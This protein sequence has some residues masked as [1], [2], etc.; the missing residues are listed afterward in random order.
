LIH[1]LDNRLQPLTLG[2]L[3]P[4]NK[5]QWNSCDKY[6]LSRFIINNIVQVYR[7]QLELYYTHVN[8]RSTGQRENPG[9]W[10]LFGHEPVELLVS[11]VP[12]YRIKRHPLKIVITRKPQLLAC[13]DGFRVPNSDTLQTEHRVW[14]RK[15]MLMKYFL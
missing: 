13:S 8:W 11:K 14:K 10:W 6:A 15:K 3:T 5:P 2:K 7:I 12:L 4:Y 9:R 1:P